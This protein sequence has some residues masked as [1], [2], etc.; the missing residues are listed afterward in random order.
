MRR[1]IFWSKIA[2]CNENNLAKKCI[3]LAKRELKVTLKSI[4][5]SGIKHNVMVGALANYIAHNFKSDSRFRYK[6]LLKVAENLQPKGSNSY[7]ITR[8]IFMK[9]FPFR[10]EDGI[11]LNLLLQALEDI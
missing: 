10:I 9:R 6:V 3:E 5:Q 2:S 1:H 7:K 8:N 4:F 11:D